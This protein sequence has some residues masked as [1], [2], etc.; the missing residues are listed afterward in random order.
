LFFPAQNLLGQVLCSRHPWQ[1]STKKTRCR[2][3]SRI[4]R[5]IP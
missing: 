3:G 5:L 4:D 2:P 1:T